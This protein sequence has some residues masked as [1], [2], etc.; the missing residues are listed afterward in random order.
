MKV[1]A[2]I[3]GTGME[4]RR[5]VVY[6]HRDSDPMGMLNREKCECRIRKDVV[7]RTIRSASVLLLATMLQF[8]AP[9]QEGPQDLRAKAL[10]YGED[11]KPQPPPKMANRASA[12]NANPVHKA[13]PQAEAAAKQPD[14]APKPGRRSDIVQVAQVMGPVQNLGIRYNLL[15]HRR[16]GAD[17]RMDRDRVFQTGECLALQ[18]ESNNAG[19]LYVFTLG[20]S[21]AWNPLLPS[22]MAPEESNRIEAMVSRRIPESPESCFRI[23]DPPGE[24]QIFLVVSRSVNDLYNLN[25]LLRK[26]GAG[27]I[28]RTP[29]KGL[30]GEPPEP[31][32]AMNRE[33]E[34][35]R[36]DLKTRDLA[37]QKA[38]TPQDSGPANSVY[39]VNASQTPVNRVVAEFKVQHR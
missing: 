3:D 22:A 23:D 24:E 35:I 1:I 15:L 16:G 27:T 33:V 4:S 30:K 25:Q 31:V 9:A 20:S 39:V 28:D 13:Q 38:P 37:W 8:P 21:G 11:P 26:R 2:P 12:K 17:E 29:V 10:Y 5:R 18:V 36:E 32:I 34:N 19:Y 14:P 7:M 6:D